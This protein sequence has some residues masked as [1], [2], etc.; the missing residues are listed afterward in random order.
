V[1]NGV[2]SVAYWYYRHPLLECLLQKME[3]KFE[4]EAVR[5]GGGN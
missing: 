2:L 1:R 4:V 5:T 3:R